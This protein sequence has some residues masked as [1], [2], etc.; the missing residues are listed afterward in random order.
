[1]SHI[2]EGADGSEYFIDLEGLKI[3]RENGDS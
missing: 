3:Q 1:M 2:R